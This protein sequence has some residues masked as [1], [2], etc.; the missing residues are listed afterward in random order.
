M[1]LP[2]VARDRP[3]H[4]IAARPVGLRDRLRVLLGAPIVVHFTSPDGRCHAACDLTV[5]V[6]GGRP[7]IDPTRPCPPQQLGPDPAS[8][9]AM[10]RHPFQL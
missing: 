5:S 10:M 4:L 1:D 2:N 3:W 6:K 8:P 9:K 7:A